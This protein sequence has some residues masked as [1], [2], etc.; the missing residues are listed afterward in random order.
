MSVKRKSVFLH[1]DADDPIVVSDDETRG[2][3]TQ[4]SKQVSKGNKVQKRG[5]VSSKDSRWGTVCS[6][7]STE[8]LTENSSM[9][10]ELNGNGGGMDRTEFSS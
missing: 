4:V 3:P 9:N 10:K 1:C 8:A 2:E 7:C 6:S 5:S